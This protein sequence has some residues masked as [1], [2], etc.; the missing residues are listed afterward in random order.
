MKAGF[1]PHIVQCA[2]LWRGKLKVQ[3]ALSDKQE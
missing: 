3:S 2:R 1:S